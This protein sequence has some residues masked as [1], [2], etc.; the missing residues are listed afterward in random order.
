G[1]FLLVHPNGSRYWR[2]KYRHGGKEKVFAI[3]VYPDVGLADART[4]ALD[5]RRLI[6]EGRDPVIE[7]R[8]ERAVRTASSATTFQAVAEEW[9]GS[10]AAVW[11]PS[12]REAVHSA[13]AAN[14]YPQIGG[15][16]IGSI[17]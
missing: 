6:K 2:L 14:L 13:L 17:T 3:G 9:I 7:R 16:P 12:Y 1:L 5:S 10:R 11:S 4:K 15:L 8:Q